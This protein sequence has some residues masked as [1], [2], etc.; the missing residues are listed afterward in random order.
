MTFRKFAE[1]SRRK[2]AWPISQDSA[3]FSERVDIRIILIC[4]A[5][6]IGV[7]SQNTLSL[8]IAL[9]SDGNRGRQ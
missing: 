5:K 3:Q 8:I 2:W 9:P 4:A 7:M 1:K 6:Y